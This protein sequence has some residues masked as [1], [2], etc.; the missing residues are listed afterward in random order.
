M[1]IVVLNGSPHKTGN[2]AALVDA[3]QKGATSAGHEVVVCPVGTMNIKGCLGCEYCHTKGEGACIQKDDMQKVYPELNSAD[4]VV[5][6]SPIASPVYYFGISGQMQSTVSRFYAGMK[7]AK[8]T[9]YSL[10]LS[11]ASPNVYAGIETQYKTMVGFFG[12]EDAGIIE[13]QRRRQQERGRSC[14]SRGVRKIPVIPHCP[15]VKIGNSGNSHQ[16]LSEFPLLYTAYYL[17]INRLDDLIHHRIDIVSA[18]NL[19][20]F[21]RTA[22]FSNIPKELPSLGLF[23]ID[24]FIDENTIYRNGVIH[25]RRLISLSGGKFSAVLSAMLVSEAVPV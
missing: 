10:I 2:T 11:S 3:F 21:A 5:I 8:A 16:E 22:L 24:S 12:A 17:F 18:L 7:P 13:W 25:I 6:A 23:L 14:Q 4:M 15:A 19:I 9:K 1:K 20:Y